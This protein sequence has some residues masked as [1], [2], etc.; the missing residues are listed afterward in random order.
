M[1]YRGNEKKLRFII[2]ARSGYIKGN[3]W[4]IPEDGELNIG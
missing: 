1:S 3:A 2:T 4:V